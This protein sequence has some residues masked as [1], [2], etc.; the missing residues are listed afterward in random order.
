MPWPGRP[1]NPAGAAPGMPLFMLDALD[2]VRIC[3]AVAHWSCGIPCAASSCKSWSCCWSASGPM[4]GVGCAGAA[5]A[6]ACGSKAAS[7]F[8][9]AAMGLGGVCDWLCG[10]T[11]AAGFMAPKAANGLAAI[12]PAKGFAVWSIVVVCGATP[13]GFNAPRGLAGAGAGA[14]G[15]AGAGVFCLAISASAFKILEV[16]GVAPLGGCCCCCCC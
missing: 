9:A 4:A 3:S 11:M 8:C 16:S 12:A 6:V 15:A 14:A 7:G 2:R 5:G 13:C 10:G 1:P